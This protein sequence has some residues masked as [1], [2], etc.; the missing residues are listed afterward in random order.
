MDVAKS[1]KSASR[2]GK[3]RYWERSKVS[4]KRSK[5]S[6]LA[7]ACCTERRSSVGVRSFPACSLEAG[8]GGLKR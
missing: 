2:M 5:R 3:R 1:A 7:V 4:A 6:R 8:V